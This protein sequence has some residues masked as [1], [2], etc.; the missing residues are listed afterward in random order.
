MRTKSG[1]TVAVLIGVLAYAI[2]H[3]GSL[4]GKPAPD[5]TL[6]GA[7]GGSVE[8]ASFR[9]RPLLMIFWTTSCGAC[10]YALPIADR[11]GLEFG[12]RGLEVLAVNIGDAGGARAFIAQTGLRL[13]SAVDETGEIAQRYGVSGVPKLVLIDREGKVAKVAT[14]SRNEEALRRWVGSVVEN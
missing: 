8:L 5:F 6:Q 12:G 1:A 7:Y 2:F 4:S 3:A 13:T 9:G 10:R 11:I 14:G